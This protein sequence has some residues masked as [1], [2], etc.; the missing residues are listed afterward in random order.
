[1]I[2]GHPDHRAHRRGEDNLAE[3]L[4]YYAGIARGIGEV[5]DSDSQLVPAQDGTSITITAAA[6]HFSSLGAEVHLIDTPGRVD[7]TV[8]V[9]R[10][11][12]VLDGAVALFCGVGG[13]EPQSEVFWRQADPHRI[14]RLALVNKLDR[15]G[16]DFDRGS[17]TWR[18]SSTPAAFQ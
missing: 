17:T 16:A 3:R 9:E 18:A 11:L 7:F 15:P 14:P 4:L 12:R 8:E 1:M 2:C 10:S 5:H 13:V 6:T